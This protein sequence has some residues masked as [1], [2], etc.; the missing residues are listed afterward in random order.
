MKKVKDMREETA[1][2]TADTSVAQMTALFPNVP[3]R[4]GKIVNDYEHISHFVGKSK[5]YQLKYTTFTDRAC[6]GVGRDLG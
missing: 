2:E 4:L 1:Q 6:G 5:D 3:P